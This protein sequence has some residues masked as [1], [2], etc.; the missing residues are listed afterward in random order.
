MR[1]ITAIIQPFKLDDV[2]K[3]LFKVGVAG[4]TITEVRGFGKQKG[5][6]E[7]YRGSKYSVDFILKIKI[8]IASREHESDN[9]IN[10]IIEF[11]RTKD[12]NFGDGK[13]F[14]TNLEDVVRIRTAETGFK[15]I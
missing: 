11:A 12:G 8:E 15:A 4:M 3:A 7:L 10:T 2:K 14:I 13:I 5:H 6:I 1:L 9:I